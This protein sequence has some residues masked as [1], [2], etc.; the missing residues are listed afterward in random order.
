[1]S[2]G[3]DGAVVYRGLGCGLLVEDHLLWVVMGWDVSVDVLHRVGGELDFCGVFGFVDASQSQ[4]GHPPVDGPLAA[5][6]GA[7]ESVFDLE[8][9]L[10]SLEDSPSVALDHDAD[11]DREADDE[12]PEPED[13][14][15]VSVDAHPHDPPLP[16]THAD[17]MLDDHGLL[18]GVCV[19]LDWRQRDW[20][21]RKRCRH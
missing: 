5:V 3:E 1:V 2:F 21:H 17:H 8:E 14:S 15:P 10:D 11:E 12:G 4:L 9:F 6:L 16:A 7:E 13:S 19:G 20:R 18:S